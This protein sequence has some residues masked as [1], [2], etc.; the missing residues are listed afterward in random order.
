[1]GITVALTGMLTCTPQDAAA[2]R[3]A[4]PQHITLSRAEPGCLHF[5]VYETA[6]CVFEVSE[7]FVDRAAF[8]AHQARTQASDWWAVTRHL[9]R[10]FEVV[11]E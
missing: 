11:D 9:P 2:V 5:E 3:D 8:D 4:L 10:D 1:M 7:R 6:P